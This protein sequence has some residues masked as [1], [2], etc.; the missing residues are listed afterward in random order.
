MTLRAVFFDAGNTLLSLD[1]GAIVEALKREDFVVSQ[2]EVWQAEC[3]AR[4]KLDPFLARAE[5]RETPE[6]FALYM[7]LSCEE[8]G[9]PWG[10]KT[11]RVLAE[12]REINRRDN[13]WRGGVV[14]GAKEVLAALGEKGYLLGV[15]SNADGRLEAILTEK[16]LAKHL[17]AIVDSHVV[18]IEKPDPRIFQLALA[19][20]DVHPAQALYVGDFY[21]L[22]I[23]AA[24]HAGLNAIL[25]DPLGAWPPLDCVKIKDLFEVPTLLPL[26]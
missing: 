10:E 8:M 5:V 24:R 22:D 21:S 6:I 15:I 11:E 2:D 4:V 23:V 12:L 14:P 18:G 3:R 9:L 16:G 20:I 19:M 17:S 7:R 25:L 26:R 13:L 1:Y